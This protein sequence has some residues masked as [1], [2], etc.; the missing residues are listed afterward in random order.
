MRMKDK[1][2]IVAGAAWGG[3]GAASALRL[4][5]EGAQVVVNT[6]SREAKLTETVERIQEA[7]GKAVPIMGDIGDE[8]TW[9]KLIDTALE[10]FGKVTT[11]VHNAAGLRRGSFRWPPPRVADY[12]RE[13]WAQGVEAILGGPRLGAQYCI[14]EM[15][16]GGGGSIRRTSIRASAASAS[17]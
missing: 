14:P 7:G 4:A 16:R 13:Q 6:L 3:I 8:E 11:L 5:Q 1:V 10:H 9:R 12:S 15:I 2:A 17:F